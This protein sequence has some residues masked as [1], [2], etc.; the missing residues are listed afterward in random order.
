MK[1]LMSRYGAFGDCLHASHLPRLLK[2][3][4]YTIVD[5]ETNF[6]GYQ[7]FS[8]NPFIDNLI[9]FEPTR[10]K[11]MTMLIRHWDYISEGYDKFINLYHSLEYKDALQYKYT[12][13]QVTFYLFGL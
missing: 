4:G 2:E 1:A 13:H 12:Y 7:I 5:V 10:C 3:V 11:T 9:G 6:K 8:D